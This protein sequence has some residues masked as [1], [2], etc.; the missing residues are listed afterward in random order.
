ML[1]KKSSIALV[2]VMPAG[3]EM[4][5]YDGIEI[6]GLLDISCKT[7]KIVNTRRETLQ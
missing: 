4:S 5:F 7:P 3:L 2:I 1:R 6:D